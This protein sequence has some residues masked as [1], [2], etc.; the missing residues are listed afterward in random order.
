[1]QFQKH[2]LCLAVAGALATL[3][4]AA[5]AQQAQKVEKIEVTGSN[6]KRVE[7]EQASPVTV[8][9]RQ[10]IEKSG[11]ASVSDVIRALPLDNNGSISDSFGIGF[12][13]G[14]SGVSLRGLTVNSTLVL[15][16]GRRMAPY[17]LADDGQRSFVDLNAIPLDAVDR[18]E[19]LKDGASAI[20]GS[21]AIAGVVNVILR[22]DFQGAAANVSYGR[23]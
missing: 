22:R 16:N 21:D 18:I 13:A 1:M 15:L 19:V 6:I 11:A 2:R 10:D 14:A 9:T 4:F 17:G 7:A 5:A 8:V 23:S 20:Y 3:P 12:A